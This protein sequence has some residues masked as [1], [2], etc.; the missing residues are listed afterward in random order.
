MTQVSTRRTPGPVPTPR[1]PARRG[2]GGR[3]TLSPEQAARRPGPIDGL[4]DAGLFKALGDPTRVALLACLTKCGRACAVGEI[5]GCCSV[6]L[7]VVSRHLSILARAG[8][9]EGRR[10]GKTVRYA[11]RAGA[12]ARLLRALADEFEACGCGACGCGTSGAGACGG[13]ACCGGSPAGP[14]RG[15]KKGALRG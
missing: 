10:E 8:V 11:V 12:F 9:I 2:T 13:G 15:A 4:L 1:A 7:S 5:A 6:D 3:R 14:G